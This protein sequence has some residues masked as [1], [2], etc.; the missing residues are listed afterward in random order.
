MN[1]ILLFTF[2]K[3]RVP[4]GDIIVTHIKYI[5][6]ANPESWA[7]QMLN[8][9]RGFAFSRTYYR[10]ET[11]TVSLHKYKGSQFSSRPRPLK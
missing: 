8:T 6:D 2:L 4:S 9:V 3:Y 7:R 11:V 5:T 10:W 1:F